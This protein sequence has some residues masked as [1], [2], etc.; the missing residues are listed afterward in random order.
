MG[1]NNLGMGKSMNAIYLRQDVYERYPGGGVCKP[2]RM[3]GVASGL[4]GP[5]GPPGPPGPQGPPGDIAGQI[6]TD[7]TLTGAGI[8]VD[9]LSV[10][11]VDGGTY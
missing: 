6:Y 9:P 1:G 5:P 10:L 7:H 2:S 4:R 3:V 8:L 11:S